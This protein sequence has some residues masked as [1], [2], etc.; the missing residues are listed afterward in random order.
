MKTDIYQRVTDKIVADLEQG[1]LTWVRPW[2][3]EHL[4]GR[5]SRPRRF[6]GEPYK[7]VNVILL[8]AASVEHGF[9]S[10]RWMT[11]HQA[12]E[13]GGFVRKGEKGE[14]VVYADKIVK[15]ETD[16]KSGD[17]I[18]QVIPFLKSYSVFNVEQIDD[19]APP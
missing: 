12:K 15:T 18:E 14:T 4:G 8:W 2:N 9:C 7:G 16:A 1:N 5:I 3:A 13:L 6:S 11:F 17:D 10:D 19:L